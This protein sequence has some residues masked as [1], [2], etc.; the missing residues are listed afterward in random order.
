[1]THYYNGCDLHESIFRD[2]T[3]RGLFQHNRPI[4]VLEGRPGG[5]ARRPSLKDSEGRHCVLDSSDD[6]IWVAST[7]QR[8]AGCNGD[9]IEFLT[10]RYML[11]SSACRTISHVALLD[12]IRRPGS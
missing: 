12:A 6:F 1:M 5:R 7:H 4:A 2:Q 8:P 9:R 3:W 10:M 11:P